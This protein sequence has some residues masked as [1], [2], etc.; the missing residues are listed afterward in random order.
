MSTIPGASK[1]LNSST[2]ANTKGLAAQ[3]GSLLDRAAIDILSVG[4]GNSIPGIGLSAN[5]R[6]LT[7]DLLNKSSQ[8]ANGLFSATAGADS[9]IEGLQ[10]QIA[11]LRSTLPVSQLAP[12]R[13]IDNGGVSSSST[14]TVVDEQV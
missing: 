8:S 3:T 12:G 1:F 2:L 10:K 6:A 7:Q 4:R 13:T 14:G 11:A 9:T 5:S